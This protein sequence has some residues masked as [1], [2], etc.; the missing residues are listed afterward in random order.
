VSEGGEVRK[1][2]TVLF[3]DVT[4]S[5]SLGERL[6]SESL[7]S[8]MSRYFDAA[9]TVLERHGG[10][11]EKFIGDAVMA[12]FGVPEVHEDDALRAARAAVELR[13]SVA[14]LNEELERSWGARLQIRIGVNSGDV[15]AGDPSTGQS[16]VSGDAV[17][18]AAR[19]EQAAHPGEI[20]LGAET[21]GLVRDAV[22][23][24]PVEP[25]SLKGKAEPVP[26]FR[27]L[28]VLPGAPA[29]ARHLDSPMLGRDAELRVVLDA[30]ERVE[31][32]PGCEL[33][34]ILG[35]AGVGKS[36][37]IREAS[38][39]LADRARVLKG[40]C[41]PYGEGITFWPVAEI[42]KQAA[43]IDE[44]DPP[45][46]AGAKIDEL[47]TSSDPDQASLIRNQV[48]AAIGLGH[49]AGAIQETFWAFRRLLETLAD[50][51][52]LVAVIED[53]H[54]AEPT[55]LDLLEY[56][57]GFSAGHPLLLLCTGR[58]EVRDERPDWGRTGTVVALAPLGPS[59]SEQ[60]I[61]NLLGHTHLPTE[62]EARLVSSAE[63]NPLFV[64]EMLR[65]L[66]DDGLLRRDD[67]H[68]V[69]TGDLSHV[70]APRT[71]QALIAAR[72]DRLADE[73]RAVMQRASVAGK[74][75]YWG[76]VTELS[77][78][79]A[80]DTVGGSLQTLLRKE[81]I[82]P[83]SS[84][85]AGEDAFRFSHIL[86]HDAA[87]G[88]MPKRTRAELHERFA[89]WLERAAGPRLS[90][91][92]EILGYHLEQAHRYLAELGP[93]DEHGLAVASAAAS[94][95]AAAGRRAFARGDMPAAESL[96][97][98]AADLLPEREPARVELLPELGAVRTE[99]GAWQEAEAVFAEAIRLARALGDRRS[100][101]LAIV[102][103][104]WI[105]EHS[106]AFESNRDA[107]PELERAIGM[108]EELGDEGGLADGWLLHGYIEFWSGS[109][110]RAV[111]AADRA[112]QHARRAHDLR[113]ET[114]ALRARSTWQVWGPMPA[115]EA[116]RALEEALEGPAV[117]APLLRAAIT[118]LRA[119]VEA[120]LGNF[121]LARDL[122]EVAKASAKEFGLELEYAFDVSSAAYIS[123]LE[124]DPGRAERDASEA[125]GLFRRMGDL[126][127]LSSYAPMLA[128]ALYAQ[129]R[130]DEALPL[131][132][133]AE[134]ATIEGD[135]DAEV[136]WRRV[137][138]KI[139]ARQGRLDEA[140]RLATEA[141]EFAR[142]TDDLDKR[143]RALM[144]LAEVLQLAGRSQDAAAIVREALDTFGRKGHV[145]MTRTAGDWLRRLGGSG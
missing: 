45:D 61:E 17:N 125:V 103:S 144:D 143:G 40:R 83:E 122:I 28:E 96:L 68:W 31:R 41:L 29:F 25:L 4:G 116:A 39:R 46:E 77:P 120:M 12:V 88:S 42:V 142:P 49:A 99:T 70:R 101:G 104:L 54:W 137:R 24:D 30:F 140:V 78:E 32:G 106:G 102:R 139:L 80:R 19:L 34:T 5:T 38:S 100:E 18:V 89:S 123:M 95:L 119:I 84:P 73:E 71:I 111:D 97:S 91:F 14:S 110:E 126:G 60:L 135:I 112:I 37:L 124:G 63:G 20:L 72:L 15:V 81:L 115:D 59:E 55:L 113:R 6:D 44:A 9:R 127:H 90:E 66:I 93:V 35:V 92:E 94:R 16:F 141:I 132:E 51:R 22:R 1:T 33:V 86:V 48:G 105:Q 3:S 52:P 2:V 108:F 10:T 131:T 121:A 67:G 50:A 53:I 75:F 87:Y 85:F 8:V 74:V 36:R 98:R 129:G 58:P 107:L 62:V 133:E 145:V 11:V 138:A 27:L 47:L 69:A 7:R 23:V 64:E 26:T 117:A 21:L 82:L 136:H 43:G 130:Y 57:A 134:R 109:A 128:E 76:A 65:M 56:V 118:R 13:D 114:A 79:D